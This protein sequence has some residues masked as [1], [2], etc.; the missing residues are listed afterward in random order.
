[1]VFT[2]LLVSFWTYL[3]KRGK[4]PTTPVKLMCGMGLTAACFAI[5]MFAGL[6]G[7]DTGRVSVMWIISS[8]AVV[9]LGEL[10]LSPMGLSLVSRMAP[11]RMRGLMMGGWFASTAIGN[12]LSGFL[13]SFWERLPHSKFFGLLVI[14]SLITVALL[15][16]VMKKINRALGVPEQRRDAEEDVP[17][18]AVSEPAE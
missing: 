3:R 10:C 1:V 4:E 18:L 13:G 8:Y 5:M 12:Y 14:T 11:P 9:T 15:Y 2:P 17:P 7:G 6:A 16:M